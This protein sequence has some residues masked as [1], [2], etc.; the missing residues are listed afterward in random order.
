[1]RLVGLLIC[2][3]NDG[4]FA[5]TDRE[6]QGE[7]HRILRL[8]YFHLRILHAHCPP[9]PYRLRWFRL[10]HFQSFLVVVARSLLR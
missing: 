1:M 5:G 6:V 7:G 2:L 3:F 4:K 8:S 9:L 10:P